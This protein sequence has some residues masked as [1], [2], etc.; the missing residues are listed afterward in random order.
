VLKANSLIDDTLSKDGSF[1]I[2]FDYLDRPGNRNH[3]DE[4]GTSTKEFDSLE[5]VWNAVTWRKDPRTGKETWDFEPD[6]DS[7][8]DYDGPVDSYRDSLY[9]N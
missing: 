5:D 1:Q 2:E 3:P 4:Y 6:R 9:D 7:G 8:Y